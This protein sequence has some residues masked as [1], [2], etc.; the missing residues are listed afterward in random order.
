MSDSPKPPSSCNPEDH[1]LHYAVLCK[2]AEL[3]QKEI[4]A[5]GSTDDLFAS[6][7][8]KPIKF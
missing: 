8:K 6:H 3:L 5:I 4:D 7:K 2:D 1:P